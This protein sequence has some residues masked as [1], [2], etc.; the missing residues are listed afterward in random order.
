MPKSFLDLPI[1]YSH[2][3]EAYT[4]V[5]LESPVTSLE[6]WGANYLIH[7]ILWINLQVN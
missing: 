7:K 5:C 3:P 2:L 4:Q 1:D 6:D